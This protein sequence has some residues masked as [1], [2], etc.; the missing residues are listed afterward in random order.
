MSISKRKCV[1]C[2][3][4]DLERNRSDGNHGIS[5]LQLELPTAPGV[6]SLKKA[7]RSGN[8]AIQDGESTSGN[9]S[10]CERPCDSPYP[11]SPCGTQPPGGTNVPLDDYVHDPLDQ[12]RKK[13]RLLR[14]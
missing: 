3:E 2:K 8:C 11:I 5:E 13:F 6:S 14:L 9:G 1:I 4:G 7:Q 10:L 12:S